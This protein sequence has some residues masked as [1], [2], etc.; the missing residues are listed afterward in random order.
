MPKR[1]ME[2]LRE[3]EK[4]GLTPTHVSFTTAIICLAKSG[5]FVDAVVLLHEMAA[6]TFQPFQLVK[7]YDAV[8]A[9]FMEKGNVEAAL[10]LLRELRDGGLI[11][12][13]S[14][15]GGVIRAGARKGGTDFENEC[16]VDGKRRPSTA[17]TSVER[18]GTGPG[19]PPRHPP[20]K[21]RATAPAMER[22]SWNTDTKWGSIRTNS[23]KRPMWGD[24]SPSRKSNDWR[25]WNK[26]LVH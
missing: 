26:Q 15:Y 16:G 9:V 17:S 7:A 12:D 25:E 11:Q 22:Q 3:M 13:L 20:W 21:D 19:Y 24:G 1:A 18:M 5:E 6:K 2:L 8:I 14:K 4:S 23:E 10:D